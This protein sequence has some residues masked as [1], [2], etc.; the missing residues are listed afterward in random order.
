MQ[1]NFLLYIIILYFAVS[2]HG[3]GYLVLSLDKR[4]TTH[5]LGESQ[6]HTLDIY[7]T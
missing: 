6:I 3:Q 7:T 2:I 4:H 1:G 5:L